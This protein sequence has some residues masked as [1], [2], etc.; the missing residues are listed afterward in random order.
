MALANRPVMLCIMPLPVR[1]PPKADAQ[2]IRKTVLSMPRMPRVCT[3]L[4]SISLPVSME[5]LL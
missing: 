2:K 3:R 5:V 4:L 1:A